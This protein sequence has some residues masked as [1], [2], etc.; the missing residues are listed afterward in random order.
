MKVSAFV[1]VSAL[2]LPAANVF[3]QSP[4]PVASSALDGRAIFMDEK[5]GNCVSCHKVPNDAEMKNQSNLGPA[6]QA[7]KARYPDQTKLR[8]AIWDLRKTKPNTIMPPYGKNRILT[9]DEIDAV[10]RYLESV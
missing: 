2:C 6:L 3:A 9:P 4:A 7:N 5:K 10:I 8:D 1:F